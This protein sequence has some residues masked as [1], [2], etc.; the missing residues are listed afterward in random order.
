MK[1]TILGS[2]S[3]V[4]NIEA[5]CTSQVVEIFNQKFLIDCGEG[6]VIRLAEMHISPMKIEHI[7]ISHKHGDHYLGLPGLLSAM[8]LTGRTKPITIHCFKEIEDILAPVICDVIGDYRADASSFPVKFAY[9]Y[10]SESNLLLDSAK[11]TVRTLPLLHAI[12]CCGFLFEDKSSNTTKRYAYC[13]DTAYYE[14][15]ILKIK[16][17]DLL[18]HE[19]TYSDA[20]I[21]KALKYWHSTTTDAAQIALKAN[22]VKLII[23]HFSNRYRDLNIL[24]AEAQAIFPDTILAKDKMTIQI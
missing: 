19:A 8:S 1:L 13:S 11:Y 21:D 6:T 16:N 7:F 2:N 23:G 15:L 12:P 4:A 24:L 17:V 10:P 3:A 20:D 9:F 14:D 22:A 18:Y 5:F